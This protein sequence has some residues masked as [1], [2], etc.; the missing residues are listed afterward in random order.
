M[1]RF[2]LHQD[3]AHGAL[4]PDETLAAADQ[5][6]R[7]TVGQIR[8][9]TFTCMNDQ[10]AFGSSRIQHLAAGFDGPAHE[11]NIV[12]EGMTKSI[13]FDEITL[14]VDH[15]EGGG[16]RVEGEIEGLCTDTLVHCV[17]LRGG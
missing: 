1:A 2:T 12:T 4:L 10:H 11:G 14:H 3:P 5:L 8:T 6:G 16:C 9:M 7:Q 15:D 17:L 13:R